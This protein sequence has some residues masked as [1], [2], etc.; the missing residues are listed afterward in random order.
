MLDVALSSRFLKSR[1]V[2]ECDSFVR[3]ATPETSSRFDDWG[4]GD[5]HV[6]VS[7]LLHQL[8]TGY[9]KS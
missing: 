8:L 5:N 7:P 9:D 3:N 4:D 1:H 2:C 6:N